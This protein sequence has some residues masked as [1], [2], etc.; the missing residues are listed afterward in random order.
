MA[1][2]DDQKTTG[3]KLTPSAITNFLDLYVVG[4]DDAKKTLSVAVYA[5]YRRLGRRRQDT[6][7]TG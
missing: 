2:Q 7:E 6:V 3:K 1:S 4:Q 5:H